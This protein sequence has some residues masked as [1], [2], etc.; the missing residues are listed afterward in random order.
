MTL[1]SVMIQLADLFFQE[2]RESLFMGGTYVARRF[3]LKLVM[4]GVG[5]LAEL[6]G[7]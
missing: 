4:P 1:L 6:S 7:T 5:S 3:R 2:R